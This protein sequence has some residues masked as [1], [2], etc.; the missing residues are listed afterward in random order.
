MSNK[1]LPNSTVQDILVSADYVWPAAA[2]GIAASSG[3]EDAYREGREQR[4]EL[5]RRRRA[6]ARTEVPTGRP[7]TTA[8]A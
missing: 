8:G 3:L 1:N 7:T 4:D 6:E 5:H 2:Y